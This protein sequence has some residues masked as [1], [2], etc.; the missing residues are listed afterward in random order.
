VGGT[1]SVTD[2]SPLSVGFVAGTNGITAANRNVALTADNLD[3]GSRSMPG[4]AR[5]RCSRR[6][7]AGPSAW[8]APMA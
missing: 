2:S 5:S 1:L 8:A 7:P 4:A 6:A 3:T